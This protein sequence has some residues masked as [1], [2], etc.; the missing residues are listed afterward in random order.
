MFDTFKSV[1]VVAAHPDDEVLGFGGTTA[2]LA[3]QAADVHVLIL[4][5]GALSRNSDKN[6]SSLAIT[7]L[8]DQA[9][10]A[11]QILGTQLPAFQNFPDNAMDT[12]AM[13]EVVKVVEQTIEMVKPQLVL[14]HHGGDLN[15]DHRVTHDAVLTA[16][17]PL[18]G[19]HVQAIWAGETVS[20][21]EWQSHSL[22]PFRP[23]IHVDISTTLKQKQDALRCYVDEMRPSPHPRSLDQ[24]SD[25]ASVRGRSVGIEAAEAF[26]LIRYIG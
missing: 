12:S 21:T 7:R 23:N 19:S 1:L 24:I 3:A 20:S 15:V 8:R 2:R 5:T 13:L 26:E 22:S 25:L 17:R 11:A 4:A 14:T 10:A 6:D 18:P 9:N 16:C